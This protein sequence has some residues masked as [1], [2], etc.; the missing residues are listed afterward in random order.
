MGRI[1]ALNTNA[2]PA[3][4][5]ATVPQWLQQPFHA[6]ILAIKGE[7]Q[8]LQSIHLRQSP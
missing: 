7:D 5:K 3:A 8:L 2:P 1:H 6:L 4:A